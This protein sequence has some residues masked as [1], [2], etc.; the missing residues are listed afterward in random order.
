MKNF[1][2]AYWINKNGEP[3][4]SLFIEPFDELNEAIKNNKAMVLDDNHE[5]VLKTDPNLNFLP[6][7][8]FD[9]ENKTISIDLEI[10]KKIILNLI[11]S[12]R[13]QILKELD[14]E[15]LKYIVDQEKLKRI[16]AVK[17]ELRDLP[18]L[19]LESMNNCNKLVDL[20]HIL[21]PILTT[22]KEMI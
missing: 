15:Q 5:F 18:V 2:H 13:N 22:Y 4:H 12:R 19:I 7:Y 9:F 11:K 17:Q 10:A 3:C 20:N 8:I 16:E 6:A 14:I 1:K 21:P